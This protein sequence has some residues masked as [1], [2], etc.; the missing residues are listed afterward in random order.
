MPNFNY[1][2]MLEKVKKRRI[3]PSTSKAIV[4]ENFTR[5]Y[6]S[7]S[8]R[9]LIES[10]SLV[11]K[12]STEIYYEEADRI[13]A[14]LNSMN[15]FNLDFD[16][17]GSVPLDIHIR[18]VSDIDLLC[19][20]KSFYIPAKSESV[21]TGLSISRI[22]CKNIQKSLRNSATKKLETVYWAADVDGESCGKAIKISGGSLQRHID[23]VISNWHNTEEYISSRNRRDRAIDA[24]DKKENEL[25]FNHPFSHIDKV[26]SRD[27]LYDGAHKRYIRLLKCIKE[28]FDIKGLSS[29]DITSIIYHMRDNRL[30]YQHSIQNSIEYLDD[31]LWELTQKNNY[32]ELLTVPNETRK[33]FEDKSSRKNAL[34]QLWLITHKINKDIKNEPIWK[35][36]NSGLLKDAI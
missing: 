29:Y 7:S 13:K 34:T 22:D 12:R 14:Q 9:Y 2:D 6:Y 1:E 20:N 21:S 27:R 19:I 25:F 3:D 16:F 32:R 33:I 23:V 30:F 18:T 5:S 35:V 8:L 26:N 28:D 4:S 10:M 15:E 11:G 31:F 24:Y 17:Q 36:F